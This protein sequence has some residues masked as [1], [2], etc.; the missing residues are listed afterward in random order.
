VGK[1]MEVRSRRIIKGEMVFNA[2]YPAV[3]T[4]FN[5]ALSVAVGLAS[6]WLFGLIRSLKLSSASSGSM[7]LS[8]PG[9]PCCSPYRGGD[10]EG[11]RLPGSF[12]RLLA[13]VLIKQEGDNA[14]NLFFSWLLLLFLA[15]ILNLAWSV[16]APS[17]SKND[18]LD[19]ASDADN[20]EEKREKHEADGHIRRIH[21]GKVKRFIVGVGATFSSLMLFHTPAL[22]RALGLNGL[23][24]AVEE[25]SARILL[26]G[27]L[28]GIVSLPMTDT[29]EE[30]SEPLQNLMN[31]LLLIMA[32]AWGY[33][34]SGMMS[35]I[36]ET[37]RNA[38]HVLSPSPSKKGKNAK[39]PNEMMDLINVRMM[40][41]IQL[42]TPFIIMCTYLFNARFAET[43]KTP[44][45]GGQIQMTFSK[46]YLQNSG[47]FVRVAL[48]WCFIGASFY[49]FGSLL[50]SFLDQATTVASAMATLGEVNNDGHVGRGARNKRNTASATQTPPPKADPFNDR[51]KKLVLTAGRVAVFPAFVLAMLAVAHLRGGDGA[52]HPG[53]GYESQPKDAPRILPVKGLLPPYS[54]QY[55]SWIANQSKPNHEEAG[56]GDA[57]LH[58]AAL[59]QSSWDSTPFRDSA[60]KKIVSWLGKETFC[61][62]PEIRSIKAVGRHVNFMLDNNDVADEGSILTYNPLTGRELLDMAPPIPVTAADILLGRKPADISSEEKSCN[63]SYTEMAGS[64]EDRNNS[65]GK[66][67]CKISDD[68][69]RKLQYPS[70]SEMFSFLGSHNFLTPTVVFPIF[71]TLAFLSCV[72]W[73]YFYSVMMIVYW[74]KLRRA[75]FLNIIA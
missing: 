45:R 47:L 6:R 23:T 69:A 26:F 13:C 75:S 25:W 37:A 49:T 56:A 28:L 8:G 63:N 18:D 42:M 2:Y 31:G 29:L 66:G 74:F 68:D 51:Y 19:D 40:L 70:F 21:P 38:A 55:M 46:Q 39:N 58:A 36:E 48:S 57:L 20:G 17:A 54:D 59:S 4:T 72:W 7:S 24:E 33:I 32:L 43:M 67:E 64:E 50:Q 52:T 35:P 61:Y 15:V 5:L 65:H 60:H 41:L 14:G 10:D 62:P 44:A 34:A 1:S 22:L 9:G 53:V 30:P 3:E 27:N 11:T 71:D 16:S 73:N 12:E